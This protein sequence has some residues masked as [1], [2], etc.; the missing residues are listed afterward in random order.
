MKLELGDL[1][2]RRMPAILGVVLLLGGLIAALFL[3]GQSQGLLTRAGPTSTPRSV[4]TTNVK[5]DSFTVSWIS[6]TK[7]TGFIRYGEEKGS[8]NRTL[9]DDRDQLSGSS[10]MYTT[11]YITVKGLKP[12]TK[13]YVKLGSGSKTYGSSGTEEPYEIKTGGVIAEKPEVDVIN[14]KVLLS[15]GQSAPGVIVYVDIP[16]GAPLSSL[17]RTTGAW[18]LT[19]SLVRTVD[20][21]GYLGYNKETEVLSILAQGADLGTA[22]AT[23]TTNNDTPVPDIALGQNLD[24]QTGADVQLQGKTVEIQDNGL[25]ANR[26]EVIPGEIV[27]VINKDGVPHSV[28]AKD[29]SFDTGLISG[30][31]NATF[32]SPPAVGDYPFEDSANPGVESLTGVLTVKESDLVGA[33][34]TGGGFGELADLSQAAEATLSVKLLNPGVSGE[35]IATSSPEIRIQGPTGTKV[36]ITVNSTPQTTEVTIDSD[37]VVGWTPPSRLETGQHTVV[38]EYTDTQG[39]VQRITRL[40]TVLAAQPS[41]QGG[42][43]AFTA[44][45]SATPTS[46]PSASPSGTPRSTMP[47]TG[48]GIPEPGVISLTI[49][50]LALGVGLFFGGI[51]WQIYYLK[52]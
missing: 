15:S 34:Q 10:E 27:T 48:S 31:G 6:D 25:S 33:G 24:L 18:T 32:T 16:G 9:S 46:T 19:L 43:P 30:G 13:Y 47:A 52:I 44:T 35:S 2:S 42:L 26:L 12:N 36:K 45:P 1:M 39:V 23:V 40:F 21:A 41:G 29:N 7:V 20:L 49:A 4:K 11:H 22:T 3:V 51:A 5:E 17:T 8:L 38:V 28:T 14:G 37:G 50:I